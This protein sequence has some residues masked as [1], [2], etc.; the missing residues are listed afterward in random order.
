MRF[1]V[2]N[3]LWCFTFGFSLFRGL[4]LFLALDRPVLVY[5]IFLYAGFIFFVAPFFADFDF[6]SFS[7]IQY[8]HIAK[9][10]CAATTTCSWMMAMA[11]A[12]VPETCIL[13]L[14][15][16]RVNLCW[17]QI[18]RA[19]KER[20]ERKKEPQDDG[21]E[22]VDFDGESL[23]VR[24]LICIYPA[25]GCR[26]VAIGC[27]FLPSCATS[28]AVGCNLTSVG[29]FMGDFLHPSSFPLRLM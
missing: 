20:E 26:G 13:S 23:L 21:V 15:V 9:L 5:F 7:P 10:A 18:E 12:W 3:L 11:M 29:C 28:T 25:R 1:C 8:V 14:I 16:M 2:V 4:V 22:Y 24:C 19:D 17:W 27:L 6:V